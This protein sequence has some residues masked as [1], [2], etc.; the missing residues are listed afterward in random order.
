MMLMK[1]TCIILFIV[2]L[3]IFSLGCKN[4]KQTE[5]ANILPVD[6]SLPDPITTIENTEQEPEVVPEE[7]ISST[8]D[9]YEEVN[10]YEQ[11]PIAIKERIDEPQ[12]E[13]FIYMD[14][15]NPDIQY[16]Y[17]CGGET[18]N[19][20]YHIEMT[21]IIELDKKIVFKYTLKPPTEDMLYVEQ[22]SFPHRVYKIY[23]QLDIE[24]IEEE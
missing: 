9:I 12:K 1:K 13:Y 4:I 14:P 11:F 7:D 10:D 16:L 5:T 3:T 8:S 23:S 18:P 2:C 24:V 17:I 22:P 21:D 15:E 6:N 20:G 19:S